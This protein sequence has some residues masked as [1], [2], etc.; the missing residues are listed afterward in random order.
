M[1]AMKVAIWSVMCAWLLAGCA[2]FPASERQV[3]QAEPVQ[4]QVLMQHQQL[5]QA[6]V[7]VDQMHQKT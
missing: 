1:R 6:V 2:S 3:R 7:A 5:T 4:Q